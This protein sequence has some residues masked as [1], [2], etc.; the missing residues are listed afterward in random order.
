MRDLFTRSKGCNI[1]YRDS[2]KVIQNIYKK[3]DRRILNLE[4]IKKKTG[5]T[6]KLFDIVPDH[7][8][9]VTKFRI[10]PSLWNKLHKNGTKRYA[11]SI[12]HKSKSCKLISKR[13][14]K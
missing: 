12:M 13:G 5:R 6:M 1:W 8:S 14:K 4:M 2:T 10:R 7:M 9:F 3:S 11:V